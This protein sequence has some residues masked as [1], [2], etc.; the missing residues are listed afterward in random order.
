MESDCAKLVELLYGH[1][2]DER[3]VQAVQADAVAFRERPGQTVSI[4]TQRRAGRCGD[5]LISV[6]TKI[7]S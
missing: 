7:T 2:G 6:I 3:P 5:Y 1:A 4:P